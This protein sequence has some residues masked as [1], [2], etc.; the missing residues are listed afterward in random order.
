MTRGRCS[1]LNYYTMIFQRFQLFLLNN[2]VF[3]CANLHRAAKALKSLQKQKYGVIIIRGTKIRICARRAPRLSVAYRFEQAAA[4]VPLRAFI[5]C[6]RQTWGRRCRRQSI[7]L[8][9]PKDDLARR[10]VGHW[11]CSSEPSRAASCSF[12]P[13]AQEIELCG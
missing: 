13:P 6:V 1:L 8:N 10:S 4:F 2:T 3:F 12:L 5:L 7:S 11:W 9:E